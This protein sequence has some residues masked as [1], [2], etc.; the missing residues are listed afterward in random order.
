MTPYI[1]YHHVTPSV[2]LPLSTVYVIVYCRW[3]NIDHGAL[4]HQDKI[5]HHHHHLSLNREGRWGTADNYATSFL[6]FPLFSTALSDLPN[7]RPVHF[8]MLSSHLFLCLPCLLP[9]FTVPCKMVLARPDERETWPYHCSWRLFTVV[10]SSSCGPVACWIL[11]RT[12]SLVRWS[13]WDVSYLA[14]APHLHGLY[15][16]LELCC[17]GPWF[18]SIQEDGCDQGAHQSY[19]GTEKNTP[20]IPN[21]F[22][23]CQCCCCLCY[24]GK[25]L[26]LGTLVSYY[27][28]RVLEACDCLKLL[29]MY[30]NFG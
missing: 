26:W 2:S 27:W 9:P 18:T 3:W 24:P 29:S 11:A 19:L 14:V 17:E 22:Q 16:S 15:S 7:S 28:A 6:H 23:P 30:F 5:H 1:C 13:I 21:W 10:R 8:L 12:P 20:V 4:D 25:H